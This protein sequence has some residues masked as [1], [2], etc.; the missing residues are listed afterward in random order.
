MKRVRLDELKGNESLKRQLAGPAVLPQACVIAG[1]PGSGKHTLARILAQSLVCTGAD[2]AERPCG[3][4]RACRKVAEGIHPDVM[5]VERFTGPEKP[6][7]EVKVAAARA[8]RE[9]AY[10]RPNEADR[11][12]YLIDRPLNVSAQNALLKLLE[13]GPD[14]ASFLILTE[15]A[16]SLLE[17]VRSR[18]L[19]FQTAPPET[20]DGAAEEILRRCARWTEA[21]CQ[22]SE[23][24]LMEWVALLQTEKAD[25]EA[26]KGVYET[27][28]R[29][30]VLAL[31]SEAGKD[32][33]AAALARAVSRDRLVRL[34]KLAEEAVNQCQ[35]NVSVGHS[36][37]WFAVRSR[38]ILR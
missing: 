22:G 24:A 19:L 15:N 7:A 14:Y 3:R 21:V 2:P 27:L 11:K 32:P 38:E 25:R 18:C 30:L 13:D 10:I 6:G 36:S 31:T 33:L 1:P 29:L 5:G 20:E 37:G 28:F 8:L 12:V 23:L 26:L 9:D 16:A 4:C 35:F 17:T 34:A